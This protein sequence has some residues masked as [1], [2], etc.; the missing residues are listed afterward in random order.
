MH[1]QQRIKICYSLEQKIA[2]TPIGV[3]AIFSQFAFC[4]SGCLVRWHCCQISFDLSIEPYS[5]HT[6]ST[7][8]FAARQFFFLSWFCCEH[9]RLAVLIWLLLWCFFQIFNSLSTITNELFRVVAIIVLAGK[10]FCRHA[11]KNSIGSI[12]IIVV[13]SY[14]LKQAGECCCWETGVQDLYRGNSY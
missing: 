12:K 11:R 6:F 14:W 8:F 2:T 10:L 4:G 3:A 1:D 13:G 5:A 7:I 9:H